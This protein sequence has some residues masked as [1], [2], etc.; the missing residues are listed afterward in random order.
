MPAETVHYCERC[1]VQTDSQIGDQYICEECYTVRGSCCPEF[2]VDDLAEDASD[3][4]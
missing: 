2:G 1:G 3:A 4:S